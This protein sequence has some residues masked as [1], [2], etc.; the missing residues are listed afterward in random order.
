MTKLILQMQMSVDGF[1]GADG[2]RD[3]LVW[4]WDDDN[5]WDEAVKRDF[6]AHFQSVD[7]L[8]LSR[9]M[10]EEGYLSHWGDAANRY[11]RDPFH[12]SPSASSTC[13]RSCRVTGWRRR[14]GSVRRSE[15]ETCRRR[16]AR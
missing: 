13:G 3:W 2:D 4:S 6:N 5:R 11:S 1:V 12:A 14:G 16:S 8:L 10:A 7:T 9:K 15:A